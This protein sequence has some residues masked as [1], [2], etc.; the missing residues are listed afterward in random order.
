M[1]GTQTGQ[2]DQYVRAFS[3][4]LKKKVH[5]TQLISTVDQH[6]ARFD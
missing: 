6:K 5:V 4:N 1:I 2:F 3:M